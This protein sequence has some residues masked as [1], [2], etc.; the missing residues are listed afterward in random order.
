MTGGQGF[1]VKTHYVW[2]TQADWKAFSD[3]LT[4]AYPQARY[5]IRP[6]HEVGADYPDTIWE[7]RLIDIPPS[8]A[9][10]MAGDIG[11]VFDPDFQPEYQTYRLDGD[12]PDI[13]RWGRKASTP[14][15]FVKFGR[16]TAPNS[17]EL[18][19][20]TRFDHSDIHY[21]CPTG[22]KAAAV[23]ARR[24]FRLVERF[25]TNRNQ[26]YFRLEPFNGPGTEFL[27]TE[28]KGS[29]FWLG[30]DAIRWARENPERIM[31]YLSTTGVRPCTE[32][33]MTALAASSSPKS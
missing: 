26:A 20:M 30:H 17:D 13:V 7:S 16:R 1:T 3:A 28:A 5:D 11:M 9:G 10:A 33:E 4:E 29:W 22:S 14:L 25:C 32:E 8:K 19:T 24:F 21:F 6:A 31:R 18:A 15:P 23:E 12:S 27:R 2:F